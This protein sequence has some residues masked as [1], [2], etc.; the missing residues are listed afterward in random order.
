MGRVV[1]HPNEA[2]PEA[3]I[4]HRVVQAEEDGQAYLVGLTPFDRLL[5]IYPFKSASDQLVAPFV[6]SYLS[7]TIFTDPFSGHWRSNVEDNPV[8]QLED[9]EPSVH[10]L[11]SRLTD[12]GYLVDSHLALK[13]LEDGGFIFGYGAVMFGYE[14]TNALLNQ[15]NNVRLVTRF[16]LS[17]LAALIGKAE[18]SRR[19]PEAFVCA[20]P[21]ATYNSTNQRELGLLNSVMSKNWPL[22]IEFLKKLATPLQVYSAS[23]I[24][25]APPGQGSGLQN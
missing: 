25:W 24:V 19:D 14:P 2:A 8:W 10:V 20:W 4:I 3:D 17:Q 7:Q 22:V 1:I 21:W 5:N 23:R 12:R 16:G 15:V 6:H 13:S 11:A 9:P 18:S